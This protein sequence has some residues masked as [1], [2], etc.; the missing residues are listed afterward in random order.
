MFAYVLFYAVQ[1]LMADNGSRDLLWQ[2]LGVQQSMAGTDST[3]LIVDVHAEGTL[4]RFDVLRRS[5]AV[6]AGELSI[7][8][9]YFS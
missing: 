4:R 9:I 8:L 2:K 3:G 7:A 5:R 6:I 1:L